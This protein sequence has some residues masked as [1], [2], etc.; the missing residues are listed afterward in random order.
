MMQQITQSGKNGRSGNGWR[1]MTYHCKWR[2]VWWIGHWILWG[3]VMYL[4]TADLSRQHLLHKFAKF[5]WKCVIEFS[6]W[7]KCKN[8]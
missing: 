8:S 6:R 3:S 4:V 7:H 5:V 2:F 1:R